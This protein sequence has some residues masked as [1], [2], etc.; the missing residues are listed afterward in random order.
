M[1]KD[2]KKI[3]AIENAIDI[4]IRQRKAK[5]SY[6]S[7]L[8]CFSAFLK[9]KNVS[10]AVLETTESDATRYFNFLLTNRS[11]ATV[12]RNIAILRGMFRALHGMGFLKSNSFALLRLPNPEANRVRHNRSLELGEYRS[13]FNAIEDSEDVA[14]IR[15]NAMFRILFSHAL[16]IN[17]VLSLTINDFNGFEIE[18]KNRK[19]GKYIKRQLSKEEIDALKAWLNIRG[20]SEGFLFCGV[21]VLRIDVYGKVHLRT[22][23]R[24]IITYCE[25][26][27]IPAF[28]T[29]SGRVT[30]VT[31]ALEM[32]YSYEAVAGLTGHT[33]IKQVERYDRR[34]RTT[35]N[36]NYE[37]KSYG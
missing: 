10:L 26:A 3:L 32:G 29:H 16:R 7:V 11:S 18:V 23:N 28:T 24:R 20:R 30:A 4:Y 5:E 12:N 21:K 1:K 22:V 37:G 33:S 27:S 6:Y 8:R 9:K 31:R 15:D 14:S 25:R 13:F 17:E 34:Q 36:I 2:V 35:V 19:A